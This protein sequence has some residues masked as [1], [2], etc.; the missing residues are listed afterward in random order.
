MRYVEIEDEIYI[1]IGDGDWLT[2]FQ[3][4]LADGW[5]KG[6]V[7]KDSRGRYWLRMVRLE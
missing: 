5:R 1:G 7:T 2:T 4:F 6:G 3:K